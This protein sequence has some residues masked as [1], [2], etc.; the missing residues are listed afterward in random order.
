LTSPLRLTSLSTI[1]VAADPSPRF[2]T[3]GQLE[4]PLALPDLGLRALSCRAHE[5]E[6]PVGVRELRS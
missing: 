5:T 2:A 3:S 6:N 1:T 4:S